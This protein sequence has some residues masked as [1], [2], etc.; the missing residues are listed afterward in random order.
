MKRG[1]IT[2][3]IIVG[4]VILMSIMLIVFLNTDQSSETPSPVTNADAQKINIYLKSCLEEVTPPLVKTM[5][6]EGGILNGS[7]LENITYQ[8]TTYPFHTDYRHQHGKVNELITRTTMEKSLNQHI[9]NDVQRCINLTVFEQNGYQIEEGTPAVTTNIGVKEI[10]VSLSYPIRLSK[11]DFSISSED[12]SITVDSYLGYFFD[13][14]TQIVN[15]EIEDR[16]FD[17]DKWMRYNGDTIIKRARPYPDT[18]Y[19]FR[20]FNEKAGALE[21]FKFAVKGFETVEYAD[22]PSDLP[23]NPI[24]G[25]CLTPDKNCHAN[26]V[27]QGAC[28]DAG[29]LEVQPNPSDEECRGTSR[30]MDRA[31]KAIPKPLRFLE[32]CRFGEC[33]DCPDGHKHGESWCIYEGPV[34]DG[35]DQPG[36]RHYVR[37]CFDGQIITEPC[38]DYREE[39]CVENQTL[40][41]AICRPNRWYDCAVQT[42]Q[43]DCEDESKR[44]CDWSPALIQQD[45]VTFG[46]KRQTHLCHPEVP[47]GF[48]HWV[49]PMNDVCQMASEHR[50]CDGYYCPSKMYDRISLNCMYQGDCG[51]GRNVMEELTTGGFITVNQSPAL[52]TVTNRTNPGAQSILELKTYAMNQANPQTFSNPAGTPEAIMQAM[53]D[54]L[55]KASGWDACDFCDCVAGVPVGGCAQDK[56]ITYPFL[57]LA[58]EAPDGAPECEQCQNMTGPCT[59]YRCRSIGKQCIYEEIDGFGYCT[60]PA[61]DTIG[62]SITLVNATT[63]DQSSLEQGAPTWFGY[64]PPETYW[65]CNG[66]DCYDDQIGD[67]GLE[68]NSRIQLQF[69]LSEPAKCKAFPLPI[70]EYDDIPLFASD[71]YVKTFNTSFTYDNYIRSTDRMQDYLESLTGYAQF[72]MLMNSTEIYKLVESMTHTAADLMSEFGMD[73]TPAIALWDNFTVT[74]FPQIEDFLDPIQDGIETYMAQLESKQQSIFVKCKDRAGNIQEN[75]ILILYSIAPDRTP[76]K[77][78]HVSPANTSATPDPSNITVRFNE[79]VECKYSYTNKGYDTMT[80]YMDCPLSIFDLFKKG[81][82]CTMR[83]EFT[84]DPE[85]IYLACLDQPQIEYGFNITLQNT[86]G[87]TTPSPVNQP[88]G[89]SSRVYT[90][91]HKIT[92]KKPFK[93]PSNWSLS[94][95]TGPRVSLNLNLT[96]DFKCK[97]A[98]ESKPYKDMV[99]TFG[100]NNKTCSTV[101]KPPTTP[102]TTHIRCVKDRNVTRNEGR[103]HLRYSEDI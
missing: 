87:V 13:L 48:K 56:L 93:L 101:I 95:K 98:N 53:Q 92:I 70:W 23:I 20:R 57:C 14:R 15:A 76:P 19:S 1:Q 77:I 64:N 44:D 34:G 61:P 46:I 17:I 28:T 83:L 8:N 81:Y 16:F 40:T 63:K 51:A 75:E 79:P 62:P 86:T 37:K 65:L 24:S 58:W 96:R 43:A 3:F 21:R 38:R 2:A 22:H 41:T 9:Q 47:P 78:R 6:T 80:D 66:N 5:T 10:F 84:D 82:A 89:L 54:F 60:S 27:D 12:T 74:L 32:E 11:F 67:D 50:E 42:N 30:I 100:C 31:G 45:Q 102:K 35:W 71:E 91:E 103:F 4:L 26:P 55:D 68:A 29:G 90:K 36:S 18:V 33:R 69:N 49:M 85:H 72:Y 25:Y 39:I 94:Y 73:P 7:R 88:T 99:L 97:Y 59:E 52:Y